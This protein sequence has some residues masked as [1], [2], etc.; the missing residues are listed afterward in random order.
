MAI[1][2]IFSKYLSSVIKKL[3]EIPI[4]KIEICFLKPLMI[5][6]FFSPLHLDFVC[7]YKL[8]KHFI[9]FVLML[10]L[11]KFHDFKALL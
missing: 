7:T 4:Y 1:V 5:Y 9:Q 8:T 3:H 10:H 2:G 11:W 6:V